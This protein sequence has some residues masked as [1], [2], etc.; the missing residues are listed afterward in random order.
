MSETVPDRFIKR[1]VFVYNNYNGGLNDRQVIDLAKQLAAS[2]STK[3][4]KIVLIDFYGFTHKPK[5]VP[6]SQKANGERKVI[7]VFNKEISLLK[8]KNQFGDVNVDYVNKGKQHSDVTNS[9]FKKISINKFGNDQFK[10]GT[11][12]DVF[13]GHAFPKIQVKGSSITANSSEEANALQEIFSCL[14][15][16]NN[17]F[18]TSLQP[19]VIVTGASFFSDEAERSK[20]DDLFNGLKTKVQGADTNKDIKKG[21]LVL[22]VTYEVEQGKANQLEKISESKETWDQLAEALSKMGENK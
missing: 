8:V 14:S 13:F 16:C 18:E 19:A 12:F 21:L 7:L 4:N 17:K 22:S 6:I 5:Y 1:R 9:T 2:E 3:E 11:N 20:V 10:H 15:L